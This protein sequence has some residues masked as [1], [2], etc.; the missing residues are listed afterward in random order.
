[1]TNHEQK[2][3]PVTVHLTDSEIQSA[4]ALGIEAALT[5]KAEQRDNPLLFQT[6][7]KATAT[8]SDH[9]QGEAQW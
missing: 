7:G 5:P 3:V 8:F 2:T 9:W 6:S 4:I 1:M